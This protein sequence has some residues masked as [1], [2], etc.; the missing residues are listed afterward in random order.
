MRIVEEKLVLSILLKILYKEKSIIP[1]FIDESLES[2]QR[3]LASEK[4]YLRSILESIVTLIAQDPNCGR[5][6]FKQ[7]NKV[8]LY[9]Q[10]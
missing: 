10:Y 8:L 2:I 6:A 3:I 9:N 5:E 4:T 7:V 1:D